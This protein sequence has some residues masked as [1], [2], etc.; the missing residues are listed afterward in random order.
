M[1]EKRVGKVVG[2][3]AKIGVAAIEIEEEGLKIGDTIHIKGHTTDLTQQVTSM[4][5]EK[6]PIQE[7]KPGDAVGV[8]VDDRV[9]RGDT[10]YKV[11]E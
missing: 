2:Y 1:E 9:R 3:F 4:Q 10:V 5:I 11:I 7:A 6:Q 8:K